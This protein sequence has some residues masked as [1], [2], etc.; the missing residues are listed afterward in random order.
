MFLFERRYRRLT[1]CFWWRWGRVALP[2][3][4][5]FTLNVYAV[6]LY[7]ENS[8]PFT[9]RPITGRLRCI[10]RQVFFISIYNT[11]VW[12]IQLFWMPTIAISYAPPILTFFAHKVPYCFFANIHNIG[13]SFPSVAI[14]VLICANQLDPN[15]A[16]GLT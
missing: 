14:R 2:V 1:I 13:L 8:N 16:L 15:D 5:N 11:T 12:T 7:E 6:K 4:S 9:A 3:W 10:P